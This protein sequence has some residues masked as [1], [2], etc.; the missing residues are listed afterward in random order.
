M[1]QRARGLSFLLKTAQAFT[2]VGERSRQHLD[3]NLPIKPRI[4]RAIDLAHSSGTHGRENLVRAE[5]S[6]GGKAHR[7][8]PAVQLST[9][10]IGGGRSSSTGVTKRNLF[11]SAVATPRMSVIKPWMWAWNRG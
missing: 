9:T 7:F 8:S 2:V 5:P 3:G 10:L 11:P 6:A 4:F 1:I